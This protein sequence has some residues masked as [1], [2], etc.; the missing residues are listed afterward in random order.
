MTLPWNQLRQDECQSL[1]CH[2]GEMIRSQQIVFGMEHDINGIT[3]I[4]S[5]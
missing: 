5:Q 4:N 2:R 1:A 3:N